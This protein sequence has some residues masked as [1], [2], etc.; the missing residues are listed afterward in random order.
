MRAR[1]LLWCAAAAVIASCGGSSGREPATPAGNEPTMA[2]GEALIE[3]GDFEK[4]AAAFE[5]ISKREP[6]N[7]RAH[8]YLGVARK[9]RGDT[10]GAV[11]EYR[12]A[13]GYDAN[14]SEA[15]NNL[16]LILLEQ[17][18]LPNAEAELNTFIR[19]M[20]D[21]AG[22]EFNYGLVLAAM[23]RTADA[24]THF[25]KAAALDP[26]DAAPWLSLGDLRRKAKD[27]KGAL[28]MSRKAAAAAPGNPLPLLMQAEALVAM[29]KPADAIPILFAVGD[30]PEAKASELST[31]GLLLARLDEQDRAVALYRAALAKDETYATAHLLLANA[32]AR[33]RE[34]AEA[35]AHYERF[36]VL[37]PDAPEAAE[38]RGRMA[39]CEAKLAGGKK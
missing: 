27:E 1:S 6:D 24:A 11:K 12:L 21:D 18:D 32:L 29:K 13:I 16:G 28:E 4:A 39:A 14:L 23:G 7:A 9:G 25:E 3:R 19:Q 5:R 38:A 33:G 30:M 36:L 34:W 31:A 2:E 20:K 8:Y 17:G 15:H 26:K 37:S 10:A 22:G 35:K